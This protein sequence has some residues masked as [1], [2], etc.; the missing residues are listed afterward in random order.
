MNTYKS[1]MAALLQFRLNA[2]N[3]VWANYM[4]KSQH[5][6]LYHKNLI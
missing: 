6:M 2:L 1:Q 3:I 4:Q 5:S